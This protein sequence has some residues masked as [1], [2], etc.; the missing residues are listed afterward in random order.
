MSAYALSRPVAPAPALEMI[1]VADAESLVALEPVW[2]GLVDDAGIDHPFLR[3]EWIRTWWECFGKDKQL[4]VLLVT[5]DGEPIALAPLMLCRERFYGLEARCLQLIAN[6]HTQRSD[7]IVAAHA[8]KVYPFIWRFLEDH[9]DTWDVLLLPQI[10]AGS[11]TLE[12]LPALAV[13]D[14]F[15]TG[16]WHAAH[17]P[18][19][20]LTGSWDRYFNGLARKHRANLRNRL[21]RLERLGPVSMEVVH[22]G[23]GVAAAVDDGF[24]IEA[25]AWKGQAGTAIECDIRLRTF[26]SRLAFRAARRGWLRLQFLRVGGRRIAFAFS[27]L[28]NRKLYLLKPGY[29]PEFRA[30]S[31]SSL[32]CGFVLRE[33]FANGVV[34]HDFLGADDR[35]KRDW[36]PLAR[37][38]E[39]LF[40]FG[41]SPRA[42]LLLFVKFGVVP[43][44]KRAHGLCLRFVASWRRSAR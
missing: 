27:I 34:A 39:W 7:F 3:Y 6:V 35:W 15:Q 14:G 8:D 21:K 13:R 10:P 25:L 32:L 19:L 29:D 20:P 37:P 36:T 22:E 41:H 26:Y 44:I 18:H 30:Y 2:N 11:R 9:R 28:I 23:S 4:H 40:V 17:S 33:A 5:M 38:H 43:R 1:L 31:P 16:V 24:R 12:A 42:R